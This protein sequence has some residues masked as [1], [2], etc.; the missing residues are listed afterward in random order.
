MINQWRLIMI[1][2]D[3]VTVL[4]LNKNILCQFIEQMT[5]SEMNN[6][7]KNYWTIYEH[8]EHLA[9]SQKILLNRIK[10]FIEEDNPI[11]KSYGPEKEENGNKNQSVKKLLK[12]YGELRNEQI[13]KIKNVNKNIWEKE[14]RH[15]EYKKYTFEILIR[16]AILHDSF[17]MW[18]M[19]ELWIEKE[20]YIQELN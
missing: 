17:H 19:E 16:H 10:Q 5:E 7:I 14:G 11:I 9:S 2:N 18:R 3:I 12:E 4:E 8:I 15:E 6:K 1:V 20:K 13:N